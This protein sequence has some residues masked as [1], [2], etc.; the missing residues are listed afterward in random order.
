MFD[1][2]G[3]LVDSER[4]GHRVAFNEAFAEAG[5]PYRW[6]KREYGE[7]LTITGGARRLASYLNDRGHQDADP[8]AEHLHQRKIDIFTARCADGAVPAR[9]GVER[10]LRA[11][12]ETGTPIAVATTGT[13][14]WV[15]PLLDRVFGRDVFCA[16]VTGTEITALKPEPD[17]YREV[18][19]QLE[20]PA[21]EAVA[22]E[23]SRN[24]L[25]S[26]RA[27]GLTCLAVTNGYT[28]HHDLHEAALTADGFGAPGTAEV[29]AGPASA[30]P[31]RAVTPCTFGFLLAASRADGPPTAS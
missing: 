18:L 16:V 24:G 9:P 10:L 15:E 13:R 29:L 25:V 11:L 12:R 2:D 17:A 27:A 7:L 23:D 6:S 20:I 26:A 22:V 31:H 5:L 21:R 4:H 14:T 3:T 19:R 1:V 28:R 30:L 8:L